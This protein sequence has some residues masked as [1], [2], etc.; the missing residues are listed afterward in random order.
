MTESPPAKILI[1][2][3]SEPGETSLYVVNALQAPEGLMQKLKVRTILANINLEDGAEGMLDLFDDEDEGDVTESP[4]QET[5]EWLNGYIS[6]ARD[7]HDFTKEV[8]KGIAYIITIVA[9]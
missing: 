4:A 1:V 3:S 2:D 8:P 6:K 9:A 7:E 5:W